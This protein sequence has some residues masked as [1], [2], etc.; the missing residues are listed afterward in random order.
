MCGAACVVADEQQQS[1]DARRRESNR[2]LEERDRLRGSFHVRKH[3]EVL[4]QLSECKHRRAYTYPTSGSF[5]C[6]IASSR[7]CVP[8]SVPRVGSEEPASV[9]TLMG[10]GPLLKKKVLVRS[11]SV[12]KRTGT[13]QPL[14]RQAFPGDAA[15]TDADMDEL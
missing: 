2:I 10:G 12:S 6:S 1:L 8:M 14:E 15:P 4:P 13:M 5:P 11:F 3:P 7:D 9:E